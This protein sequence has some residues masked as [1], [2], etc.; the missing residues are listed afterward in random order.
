MPEQSSHADA[1]EQ[2]AAPDLAPPAAPPAPEQ[3]PLG[4]ELSDH[5]FTM[6]EVGDE[7]DELPAE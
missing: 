7:L 6:T 2:E 5:E 3:Q 4:A 1:P